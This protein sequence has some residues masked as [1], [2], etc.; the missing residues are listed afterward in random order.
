LLI[1]FEKNIYFI[2]LRRIKIEKITFRR[3]FYNMS[4]FIIF[5][6]KIHDII[7]FLFFQMIPYFVFKQ[8]NKTQ[9]CESNCIENVCLLNLSNERCICFDN[10]YTSYCSDTI[11]YYENGYDEYNKLGIFSISGFLILNIIEISILSIIFNLFFKKFE[12]ITNEKVIQ[13]I[14]NKI[15]LT[16]SILKFFTF[17]FYFI[18]I[19]VF[20]LN[21]NSSKFKYENTCPNNC[22]FDEDNLCACYD[23][24]SK[25]FTF[26]E[27]EEKM[28]NNYKNYVKYALFLIIYPL[29]RMCICIFI[30]CIST[31]RYYDDA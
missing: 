13:H 16:S 12:K 5:C 14:E 31:I 24:Y 9:T 3:D 25:S 10:N 23:N 6:I 15:C 4:C 2:I 1:T 7:L 17:L 26:I 11:Y 19:I 30:C 29:V 20:Y 28:T 8:Q 18:I 22:F 27:Q 21:I